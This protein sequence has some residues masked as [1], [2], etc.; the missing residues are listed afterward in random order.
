M[1]AATTLAQA[2]SV[3]PWDYP[4]YLDFGTPAAKRVKVEIE[5]KTDTDFRAEK[6]SD[7]SARRQTQ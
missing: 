4:L 2:A 1:L 6:S 5:N 7:S 3:R